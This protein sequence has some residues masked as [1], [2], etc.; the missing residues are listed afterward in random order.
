M[1]SYVPMSICSGPPC[2]HCGCR[3]AEQLP[4]R[5]GDKGGWY[6]GCPDPAWLNELNSGRSPARPAVHTWLCRH[7]RRVYVAAAPE[8]PAPPDDRSAPPQPPAAQV[9]VAAGPADSIPVPASIPAVPS[10]SVCP[11]CGGK[12]RVSST[13]KQ[14]RWLKCADCGHTRKVSR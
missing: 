9:P 12:T 5:S 1:G 4:D 8:A 14:F 2:P 13:R 11:D 7:C 10:A 6:A 3:D